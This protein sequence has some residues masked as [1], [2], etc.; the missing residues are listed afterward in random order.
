MLAVWKYPIPVA[1]NFSVELPE[2]AEILDVQVQGTQPCFWALVNPEEEKSYREFRLAGTGHTIK[3]M[4]S[5]DSLFYVGT[6]QLV[7]MG[8]VFHLFE[9][10]EGQQ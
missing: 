2:S 4:E 5:P 9:V 8:L 6:F 10:L 7:N 1:D 3:P